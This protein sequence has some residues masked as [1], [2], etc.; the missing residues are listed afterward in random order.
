MNKK[1]CICKYIPIIH[2]P[3]A[4]LS[5]GAINTTTG[6][7]AGVAPGRRGSFRSCRSLPRS[8]RQSLRGRPGLRNLQGCG[9]MRDA[10]RSLSIYL[11]ISPFQLP[12]SIY[13]SFLYLLISLLFISL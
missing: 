12:L 5:A 3:V 2:M 10:L 13:L 4:L 11:S 7:Q 6:T 1:K 8:L 9:G